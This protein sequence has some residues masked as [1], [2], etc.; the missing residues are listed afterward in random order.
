V[1]NPYSAE[2]AEITVPAKDWEPNK[3]VEVENILFK[4]PE[5]GLAE[6]TAAGPYVLPEGAD[7]PG[8]VSNP[9]VPGMA[10]EVPASQWYRGAQIA[11]KHPQSGEDRKLRLPADLPLLRAVPDMEKVRA[12]RKAVVQSPVSGKD[13]E[14]GWERWVPGQPLTETL[15]GAEVTTALL[16]QESASPDDLDPKFKLEKN[17]LK[18]EKTDRSYPPRYSAKIKNPYTGEMMPLSLRKWVPGTPIQSNPP[19]L[20]ETQAA[21][22]LTLTLPDV[23]DP[24]EGIVEL[25]EENGIPRT[26]RFIY[27][28]N[29]DLTGRISTDISSL[30]PAD[31]TKL[32]EFQLP[33]TGQP[34]KITSELRFAQNDYDKKLYDPRTAAPLTMAEARQLHDDWSRSYTFST[35][36]KT[37]LGIK[38]K[39]PPKVVEAVPVPEPAPEMSSAVI[40]AVPPPQTITP[41]PAA[42]PPPTVVVTP[43]PVTTPP[44]MVETPPPPPPPKIEDKRVPKRL[45]FFISGRRKLGRCDLQVGQKAGQ[46]G[47]QGWLSQHPAKE[48]DHEREY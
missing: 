48:A 22:K 23:L 2:P 30:K 46:L 15:E 10:L 37:A 27:Q 19:P 25:Q 6:L 40:A 20:E 35:G 1:K 42:K 4:L 8:K 9:H 38:P 36:F 41:P 44:P 16:G 33:V 18:L 11:W 24:I 21:P 34:C 31:F 17:D 3:V 39:E 12:Q 5:S 32:R 7:R 43:P 13:I 45:Q 47:G 28:D 26:A 29:N 14:V